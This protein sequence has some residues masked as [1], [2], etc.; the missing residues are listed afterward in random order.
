[1]T[2]P[3]PLLVE[4]GGPTSSSRPSPSSPVSPETPQTA[5]YKTGIRLG[6]TSRGGGSDTDPST[7]GGASDGHEKDR[8]DPTPDTCG[9]V[10][11]DRR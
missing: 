7:L 6:R 1:M 5:H 11:D 8:R 10:E 9:R 3:P 4:V 2:P